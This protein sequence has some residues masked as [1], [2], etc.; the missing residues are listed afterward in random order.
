MWFLYIYVTSPSL[1][2]IQVDSDLTTGGCRVTVRLVARC[3]IW[4]AGGG[5]HVLYCL[6]SHWWSQF[7]ITIH[8]PK[9]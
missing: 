5:S 3:F 9:V 4:T 2:C 8:L 6:P 1:R 7:R